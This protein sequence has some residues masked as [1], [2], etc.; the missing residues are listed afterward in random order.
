MNAIAGRRSAVVGNPWIISPAEDG[1]FIIGAP[2]F[3]LGLFWAADQFRLAGALAIFV[4]GFMRT[5]H[6]LPGF[7]RTYTDRELFAR[8]RLRFLVIPPVLL[9]ATLWLTFQ[10][11]HGVLLV[12]LLWGIWHSIMQ[13]YGF[14]R[15]YD[16]KRGLVSA[17]VSWL[18][19]LVCV[20]WFATLLLSSPLR[21]EQ[22]RA[23][24]ARS[25]V[26]FMSLVFSAEGRFWITVAT[27][28]ITGL[29]AA[30][31]IWL[32]KIGRP[33]SP[34][35]CGMLG[36]AVLLLYIGQ[37]G[38]S[39]DPLVNV[40]LWEAFHDIQYFAIVW[41][42][43]KR[44]NAKQSLNQIGRVL[45]RPQ[46]AWVAVFLALSL[47]YG[48]L[49]F[50]AEESG[51]TVL[52]RTL[53]AV[54]ITSGFLHFYYDGFI[55]KIRQPKVRQ[56]LGIVSEGRELQA[57]DPA[58]RQAAA[59]LNQDSPRGWLDCLG[60][61]ALLCLPLMLLGG[62]ESYRSTVEYPVYRTLAWLFPNSANTHAELG[63]VYEEQDRLPEAIAEY[64]SAVELDPVFPTGFFNLGRALAKADQLPAAA[65]CYRRSIDVDARSAQAYV[66]LALVLKQMG[67]RDDA[68][69]VL[70]RG[71]QQAPEDGMVLL[72]L[73]GIL[74]SAPQPTQEHL[75]LAVSYAKRASNRIDPSLKDQALY[76]LALGYTELG[77]S[78]EA[79][80]TAKQLV[81]IYEARGDHEK[82]R[83][84]QA[85]FSAPSPYRDQRPR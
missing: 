21:T 26:S 23:L 37:R 17:V 12:S 8:Y 55:W 66:Q 4:L 31:G 10:D 39:D 69:E 24:A 2:V 38:L 58:G 42:Y 53:V 20:S 11:F 56:D 73:A 22:L 70:K 50:G 45:F 78:E 33:M 27:G 81:A 57:V 43:N 44:R 52:G 68:V 80:R 7:L 32:W 62:T 76:T 35:K 64:R 34:L 71:L 46:L 1:L 16:A 40:A 77:A 59:V 65:D 18:D 67:Q 41:S 63:S 61:S 14:G 47:F 84:I 85:R 49:D 25:G 5:G 36:I 48:G 29:Y 19:W 74:I 51:H 13:L 79:T 9:G 28:V 6:H 30:Y 15:I 60:Q 75:L 82:A 72:S 3:I 54:V 83:Q